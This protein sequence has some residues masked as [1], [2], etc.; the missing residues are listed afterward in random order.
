MNTDGLNSLEPMN[1]VTADVTGKQG[2]GGNG[3][4][5]LIGKVLSGKWLEAQRK[6]KS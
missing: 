1:K 3:R 5:R 4:G 6:H 2:A